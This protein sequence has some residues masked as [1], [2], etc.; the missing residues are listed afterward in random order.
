[1][2]GVVQLEQPLTA[3]CNRRGQA[4]AENDL[5]TTVV[6]ARAKGFL[7]ALQRERVESKQELPAPR[8]S[9][10]IT[11]VKK[12]TKQELKGVACRRKQLRGFGAKQAKLH[13][14]QGETSTA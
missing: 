10:K 9:L 8:Q 1:M 13:E 12:L 5:R 11:E 2:L 6:T 4:V 14:I 3:P 7:T